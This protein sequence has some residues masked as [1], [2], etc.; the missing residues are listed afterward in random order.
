[1]IRATLDGTDAAIGRLRATARPYEHDPYRGAL[2]T[3]ARSTLDVSVDERTV[4]P[5]FEPGE[6]VVDER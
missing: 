6:D 1:M 4:A 3:E 2:G 5:G